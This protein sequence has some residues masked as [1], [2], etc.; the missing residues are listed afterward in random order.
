MTS[1]EVV[2]LKR[3]FV[4]ANLSRFLFKEKKTVPHNMK[5]GKL[6]FPLQSVGLSYY[7]SVGS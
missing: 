5:S 2:L 1:V 7:T 4:G 6:A 3:T